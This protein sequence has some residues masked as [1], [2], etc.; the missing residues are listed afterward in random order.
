MGGTPL[1]KFAEQI[2]ASPSRTSLRRVL[3]L[4]VASHRPAIR[5]SMP[6][7]MFQRCLYRWQ[8]SNWAEFAQDNS[9]L[10]SAWPPAIGLVPFAEENVGKPRLFNT[11]NFG[12]MSS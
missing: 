12:G 1:S 11:E 6:L 5:G 10:G 4:C 8:Q 7:V 9:S 2:A 3:G